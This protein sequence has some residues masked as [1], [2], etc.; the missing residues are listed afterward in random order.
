MKIH[1]QAR[2]YALSRRHYIVNCARVFSRKSWYIRISFVGLLTY[3]SRYPLKDVIL[4]GSGVDKVAQHS[5]HRSAIRV[6]D[7]LMELPSY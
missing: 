6:D 2:T 7:M 4:A 3:F 1:I 5:Q